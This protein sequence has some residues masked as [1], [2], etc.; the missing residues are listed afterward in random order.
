[1]NN[2]S[3]F[4]YDFS[5]AFKASSYLTGGNDEFFIPRVNKIV[6]DFCTGLFEQIRLLALDDI[7]ADMPKFRAVVDCGKG[8]PQPIFDQI[9]KIFKS[10]CDIELRDSYV[11]FQVESQELIQIRNACSFIVH[12]QK[13]EANWHHYSPF[14]SACAPS[15][16]IPRYTITDHY[17]VL[18]DDWKDPQ[19]NTDVVFKVGPEQF[20]AHRHH[21]SLH[22]DV[23]RKMFTIGMAETS[24][25]EITIAEDDPKTFGQMLHFVYHGEMP[26]VDRLSERFLLYRIADKYNVK[27]LKNLALASIQEGI[28]CIKITR[29]NF[30]RCFAMGEKYD[31]QELID[32]CLDFVRYDEAYDLLEKQITD[33][34]Y[35]GILKQSLGKRKAPL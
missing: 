7:K 34:N 30:E 31:S 26:V 16:S 9:K 25:V 18:L 10:E 11:G 14:L 19:G 13:I 3:I 20:R 35:M 17:K 1:M 4:N 29:E 23:F 28:R 32:K 22:S 12:L 2:E 15:H 21:I 33:E 5:Q 27:I 8:L 6:N 24:K